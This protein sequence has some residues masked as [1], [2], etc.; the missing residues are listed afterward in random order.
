[1]MGDCQ[2]NKYVYTPASPFD[3]FAFAW[4]TIPG[5]KNASISIKSV[6]RVSLGYAF[7][8][9]AMYA[10]VLS[11]HCFCKNSFSCASLAFLKSGFLSEGIN[12]FLVEPINNGTFDEI[13]SA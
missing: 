5:R 6:G 2:V 4:A 12:S 11:F 10:S 7:L 9:A 13:A 8:T 3:D 1:M